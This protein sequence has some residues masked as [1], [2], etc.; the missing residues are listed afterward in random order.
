VRLKSR[1]VVGRDRWARREKRA[2]SLYR[3]ARPAVTPYLFRRPL[4]RTHASAPFFIKGM[5]ERAP[6]N[7][8]T[9]P[10][11]AHEG[12]VESKLTDGDPEEAVHDMPRGGKYP[13]Q[14]CDED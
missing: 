9:F 13:S 10:V 3:T 11:S 7:P 12:G 8:I 2:D 14:P 4:R 6:L 5:S 1:L